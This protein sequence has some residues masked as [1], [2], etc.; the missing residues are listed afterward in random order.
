MLPNAVRL[1]QK[2]EL[3]EN[4]SKIEAQIVSKMNFSNFS[5][6]GVSLPML[7]ERFDEQEKDIGYL[8]L[9][10]FVNRE[11]IDV[12]ELKVTTT[13]TIEFNFLTNISILAII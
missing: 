5:K 13:N 11:R 1:W 6:F 7:I 9:E 3:F 10:R 2:R 8:H 4:V 12:N